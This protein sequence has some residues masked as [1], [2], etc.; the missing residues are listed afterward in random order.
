MRIILGS[1]SPRRADVMREVLPEFDIEVMVPDIDEK[2]IRHRNPSALTMAIARAKNEAIRGRIK[3]DAVVVT[4]DTVSVYR[5]MVREKPRD[6]AE[7][8][9]FIVSYRTAPVTAITAVW[10]HRVKT[11]WS[12]VVVDEA[13]VAFSRFTE[14][15][16]AAI[17]AEPEFYGSAG[18]YLIEHPLMRHR[19]ASVSGDPQ[20]V[21]GLPGRFVKLMV[22]DALKG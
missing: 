6:A 18:G 20:T 22:H 5:S 19:V 21:L 9:E 14:A 8:R 10:V 11:D 1:G 15:E 13:T 3:G 4:A 16:V 2:S 17:V 7:Q 12:S